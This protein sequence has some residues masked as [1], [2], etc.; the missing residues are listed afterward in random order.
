[1]K[2]QDLEEKT[3][4]IHDLAQG[5]AVKR[6]VRRKI[7]RMMY[8]VSRKVRRLIGERGRVKYFD[9]TTLKNN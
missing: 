4:A 6:T 5:P 2:H 7:E 8:D 3:A 9:R 1:M